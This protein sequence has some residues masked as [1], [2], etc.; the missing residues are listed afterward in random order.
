MNTHRTRRLIAAT[1]AAITLTAT[2]ATATIQA[3][4]P[5]RNYCGHDTRNY[6]VWLDKFFAHYTLVPGQHTHI[7]Q[8]YRQTGK[9][10]TEWTYTETYGVYC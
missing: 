8:R 7:V 5:P 4:D 3:A 9:R 2:A 6:G 10:G 1:L